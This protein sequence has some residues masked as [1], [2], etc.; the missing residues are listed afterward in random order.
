VVSTASVTDQNPTPRSA[1]AVTVSIRCGRDR[2]NRSNRH[3]T[4]VSPGRNEANAA[5]SSGRSSRDPDA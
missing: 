1:S 5:A 4:N 3:T 2:P